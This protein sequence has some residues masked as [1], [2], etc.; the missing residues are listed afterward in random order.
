M[1][2]DETREEVSIAGVAR[3]L[4]GKSE[5]GADGIGQESVLAHSRRQRTFA[6]ASKTENRRVRPWGFEPTENFHG[7]LRGGNEEATVFDLMLMQCLPP[8][9]RKIAEQWG[10]GGIVES[11]NQRFK[12]GSGGWIAVFNILVECSEKFAALEFSAGE[13]IEEGDELAE[14][15]GV[16]MV[17]GLPGG[18]PVTGGIERLAKFFRQQT[19]T[20]CG[21]LVRDE[22][23]SGDDQ[24]REN[25]Q[26]KQRPQGAQALVAQEI[27]P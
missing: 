14:L 10:A 18:S 19:I 17:G 6:A 3:R 24:L 8:I 21:G 15:F 7:A 16:R 9:G 4:G 12:S 5:A 11:L 27:V 2:A 23:G 1:S 26:L 22:V 20:G 25:G 13:V